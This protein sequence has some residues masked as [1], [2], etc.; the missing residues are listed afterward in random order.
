MKFARNINIIF[1]T[2]EEYFQ[3]I[4]KSMH[5][6][7]DTYGI[8]P[9]RKSATFGAYRKSPPYKPIKREFILCIGGPSSGKTHYISR[10]YNLMYY[11]HIEAKYFDDDYIKKTIQSCQNQGKS[12]ILEGDYGTK[13]KREAILSILKNTMYKKCINL[14]VGI[15]LSRHLNNYHMKKTNNPKYLFEQLEKY[16]NNYE[17]PYF[18]EGFD[19]VVD[20]PFQ[21]HFN[22]M[23]DYIL[24]FE[25]S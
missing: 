12:I 2:P 14:N 6:L 8:N 17:Y 4:P 18:Y 15:D 25:Y 3:N 16:K 24:F 13:E 9:L 11:H 7:L 10:N 1:Y 20:I 21:A 5:I 23:N 19:E 22:N